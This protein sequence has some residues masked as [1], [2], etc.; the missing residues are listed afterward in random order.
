MYG[1]DEANRE[2][3]AQAQHLY[4]SVQGNY[5]TLY[6][7]FFQFDLWRQSYIQAGIILPYVVLAP[8][9]AA[10][11]LSLGQLQQIVRAFGQVEG[12][13]QFFVLNWGTVVELQSIY[14]RLRA[15]ERGCKAGN[16]AG[17]GIDGGE[18]ERERLLTGLGH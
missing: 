2:T 9:V 10:G 15:F 4:G 18:E 5:Y 12:S 6:K 8:T 3:Q 17:E 1:E 14:R 11:G 7:A 16:E 13:L